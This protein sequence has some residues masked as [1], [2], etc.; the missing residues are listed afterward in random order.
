MTDGE[1]MGKDPSSFAPQDNSEAVF[2]TDSQNSLRGRTLDHLSTAACIHQCTW[3][4]PAFLSSL[5]TPPPGKTQPRTPHP[6]L[7]V[8][9][10]TFE[11]VPNS[12][13]EILTPV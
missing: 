4:C 5:F 1:L 3:G 11:T 6:S 8:M 9:D 13:I 7:P 10:W 2:D 12:H